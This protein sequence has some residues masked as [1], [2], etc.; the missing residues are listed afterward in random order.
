MNLFKQEDEFKKMLKEMQKN[1]SNDCSG[2]PS[3]ELLPLTL[4]Q[5]DSLGLSLQTVDE[6]VCA[7]EV[8][9]VVDS[10]AV[11]SPETHS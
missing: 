11:C 4:S 9:H 1:G 6:H 8:R 10:A 7:M 3:G 5:P 2:K